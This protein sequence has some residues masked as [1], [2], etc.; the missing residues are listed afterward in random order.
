MS[1]MKINEIPDK[2]R[3]IVATVT[4]LLGFEIIFRIT[5][6]WLSTDICQI[7]DIPEKFCKLKDTDTNITTIMFIGNSILGEAVDARMIESNMGKDDLRKYEIEKITPDGTNLYDWYFIL[8]NNITDSKAPDIVVIGFAWDD[9]LQDENELNIVRLGGEFCTIK[10]IKE[11]SEMGVHGFEM[12]GDFMLSKVSEVFTFRETIRN[13]IFDNIIPYYRK[14][15]RLINDTQQ[16]KQKNISAA[17][18]EKTA[19]YNNLKRMI[20]ELSQKK[21]KIIFVAMPLPQRYSIKPELL[22]IIQNSGIFID[23]REINEIDNT[24]FVDHMHL[25]ITGQKI[26]TQELLLKVKEKINSY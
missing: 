12:Y 14:C 24:K 8:K 7:K 6:P 1:V 10:N 25:G 18:K 16:N 13:R 19:K 2:I 15:T 26:F 20:F 17:K 3:I 23:L 11:L 4:I 22:E 5:L 21:S 9:A